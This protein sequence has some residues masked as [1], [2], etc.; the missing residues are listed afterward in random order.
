[1]GYFVGAVEAWVESGRAYAATGSIRSS[2]RCFGR[3][4]QLV[5][6]HLRGVTTPLISRLHVPELTVREHQV[7]SLAAR[8]RSNAEIAHEL[9]RSVRTVEWHLQQ[10]YGKLGVVGRAQLVDVLIP[11]TGR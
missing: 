7:A 9:G 2:K 5:A 4:Q 11:G 10:A 1:M 6:T 8:G 3:A